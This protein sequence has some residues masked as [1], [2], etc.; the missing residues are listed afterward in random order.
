MYGYDIVAGSDNP[1]AQFLR[2]MPTPQP[3]QVRRRGRGLPPPIA[4][5]WRWANSLDTA[6]KR[7]KIS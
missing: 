6:A 1:N 4:A 2:K 3:A 5:A 7:Q